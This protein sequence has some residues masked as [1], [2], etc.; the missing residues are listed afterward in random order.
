MTH[1]LIC[2][3]LYL[4][5]MLTRRRIDYSERENKER[6]SERPDREKMEP[7]NFKWALDHVAIMGLPDHP[8]K[9][10]SPKLL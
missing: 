6:E 7:P 9:I 5:V 8:S 4:T 1:A 2:V 3:N 10:I